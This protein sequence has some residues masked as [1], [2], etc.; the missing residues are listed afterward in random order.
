MEPLAPDIEVPELVIPDIPISEL[1]DYKNIIILNEPIKTYIDINTYIQNDAYAYFVDAQTGAIIKTQ[2]NIISLFDG[3]QNGNKLPK[4]ALFTI[5]KDNDSDLVQILSAYNNKVFKSDGTNLGAYGDKMSDLTAGHWEA[6]TMET[7][8]DNRVII[9][10][11]AG[12]YG[13]INA[14]G[15]FD[16]SGTK[17][18]AT[19][20]YFVDAKYDDVSLY[21]E[22]QATGKYIKSNGVDQPLTVDGVKIDGNI[23]DDLRYTPVWGSYG[24]GGMTVTFNSKAYPDTRWKGGSTDTVTQIGGAGHGGWESIDIVPNGD[25]TISFRDTADMKYFTVSSNGEITKTSSTQSPDANGKFII[26]SVLT[27]PSVTNVKVTDITDTGATVSWTGITDDNFYTGYIVEAIPKNSSNSKIVSTETTKNEIKIEGLVTGAQYDIYVKTV[28][29]TSPAGITEDAITITAKAIA[30]VTNVTLEEKSN[31]IKITFDTVADATSYNIYRAKSAYSEYTKLGTTTTTEF[32]DSNLNAEG[33]YFN[34]YKIVP[35]TAIGEAQLT[36]NFAS[37]ETQMFGENMIIFSEHDPVEKINEVTAH[38]YELQ[39]DIEADAQFNENRF[40][41]YFKPGDYTDINNINLGFYTHI[42]GLGKTPYDVKLSNISIPAYLPDN[43]ATCNF[44]RS[45]ENVSIMDVE[46]G[47]AE[48]SWRADQF[49]WGVAQAAPLRRIYSERPISYDWNYGWA[50]G[51]YVADSY[52]SGMDGD[53]NS[54][55][56]HSGQQFYTRNTTTDGNVFGTTLNN[57]FQG[58]VAP[59]IDD[60][61]SN[62]DFYELK[63]GLGYSNWNTAGADNNQQVFTSITETEKLKEKPFLFIDDDNEYKI[64][65]PSLRENTKGHSWT[66]TD[67]GEGTAMSLDKFYIA[68]EGDTAATINAQLEA[69]KNIFF[70]P[71]IYYAEEVIE[72]KGENT[73]VL[74]TGMASI[75]PTNEE[76]AMS[77]DDVSGVTVAGLIFDAG[78]YSEYLIKVGEKGATLDHSANPTMLIDLFFRIGGTTDV[79]TK[80]DIAI[81]INSSDVITD[82]FWIWRADHGAGVAW[83][84]NVS[85]NGLIVNGDD[86]IAYALFNEHFQE[87][88]TLWTGE[89]GSTFFYQ[90]ETAYDPIS[91]E[92]WMSHNGTVNGYASYKVD[93]NVENHYAVGMGVYNVFIFTGPTYD[94]TEVQIELDNAIEVPNAPNVL[95]ENA[96]IQTFADDQKVLQKINSIVNG[97]GNPVSSGTDSETGEVGTGWSRSFLISY[98]DGTAVVGNPVTSDDQKNKYIG[99]KTITDI[100]E[101]GATTSNTVENLLS[102]MTIEEKV[103]QMLQPEANDIT[104]EQVAEYHIGSL[105]SGGGSGTSGDNT[106]QEWAERATKYHKAAI[107]GF[108]IPLLY[109]VDAVHGHNNVYGATIFPHNIGLGQTGNAQLVEEIGKLTTKEMLATGANWNFTPTL[110]MPRNERWGRTYETY[111]ENVA[112]VTKLGASLIKGVQSDNRAAATAKHFIGEGITENGINQGDVPMDYDSAEFQKIL[113][114]ELALPYIEAIKQGV[115]TVMVT[116]NS[117]GGEKSHGNKALLTDYLKG[118]LGFEGIVITDYNG[119]D[120][121]ENTSSYKD[122]LVR[123]INAGIDMLMIAGDHEGQKK[124]KAAYDLILE[125]INED[126]I[127][128]ERIN[129]AVK[130]ILTVKNNIGILTN[131]NLVYPD[132]TLLDDVGSDAHRAVAR[133]AVSQS[134]V[135]LKN[136]AGVDDTVADDTLLEE[137]KDFDKIAVVGGSAD[138][139]GIQSGGWTISWQGST[140]DI[141]EGTTIY[142]GFNEVAPNAEINYIANGYFSDNDYDVAIVVVGED[143][144]AETNGD[145]TPAGL[146]LKATDISAIEEVTKNHPDLPIVAVVVA[147]RPITIADQSDHFDAIIMAGLP[148]T[149]GAGVADVLLGDEDFSGTLTFTWPWYA[150]DIEDKFTDA[151]KVM[152]EYGR[153]LTKS[154]LTPLSNTKPE[155]PTIVDLSKTTPTKIEAESFSSKHDGI[156]VSGNGQFLEYIQSGRH[157]NYKVS[158][159]EDSVYTV[160]INAATATDDNSVGLDF[161]VDDVLYSSIK[162]PITHTGGWDKFQ[163]LVVGDVNLPKGEYELKITSTTADYNIDYYQFTYKD[164]NFVRPE[165]P[166]IDTGSGAIIVE[167]GVSVTM[168]SSENSQSMA[169]Y[170]GEFAIENK[171]AVKEPIDIKNTD[172]SNITSIILDDDTTYQEVLGNGIS[173]EESTIYNLLK[174][175]DEKRKEFLTN[176]IDPVNGMGNTLIRLTIAT[177]DFTAQ[178]FYSYYDGTGTELNGKPDWNNETGNGFSIQKDIDFGIIQVVNEL[179]DIAVDLGVDDEIMFFASSWS[180]PGWMKLPTDASNSYPDNEMLLKGGSLNDEY[181]DEL[182]KYYVRFLEEYSKHGIYF[183]AMTLQNEPVLEINYP[184]CYMTGGQ[185]AELSKAVKE[186][187]AK[188]TILTQEQQDVKLWAFDHNFN[189]AH[190]FMD[191]LENAGGIDYIDGIAFH[192]Y[193]GVPS[194]MGELYE[195]FDGKLTM[196]LT[197]RAIWGAKGANDI[198]NWY[199]NGARSY[200]GWVTMLDS[201]INTHHWVGTPD[202]TLFVQDANNP[203]KYWAT[204]EVYIIGQFTKYVKEGYVRISS[205]N[206]TTDTV[207]NVAFKNPATG[208]IVMIVANGSGKEQQ[209]K[210]ILDGTQFNALIPA[211]NVATYIWEP[212]DATDFKD[213][214]EDL[215]FADATIKDATLQEDGTVGYITEASIITYNLNVPQAGTYKVELDIAIGGE[216]DKNFETYIKQGDST[217]GVIYSSRFNFWGGEWSD[218]K[219]YQTYI[220]FAEAGLQ[221]INLGFGSDGINL[222]DIHFTKE[223]DTTSLPGKLDANNTM[224]TQGLVKEGDAIKNFG[225]ISANDSAEYKVKVSANG[226]YPIYV[227]A[228]AE[229]DAKSLTVLAYNDKYSRSTAVT[230]VTVP[231]KNTGSNS[232]YGISTSS[233]DLTTDIDSI[234]VKFNTDGVN[235]RNISIGSNMTATTSEELK[236]GALTNKVIALTLENATLTD[237]V[238]TN[239]ISLELPTGVNYTVNR[240]SDTQLEIT[241]TSEA[242]V[243]F[244]TPY[245]LKVN[246]NASAF[247]GIA[248][249]TLEDTVTILAINDDEKLIVSDTINFE[250][251]DVKVT[252]E[253]GTF[254]ENLEDY[255]T[256]TG[257]LTEYVN[258]SSV[259]K[260]SNNTATISLNWEPMYEDM[261]GTI[262]ITSEGYSEGSLELSSEVTFKGTTDLPP[263]AYEI[264]DVKVDLNEAEAFRANGSL[265]NNLVKGNYIDYFVDVK[266][267]GEYRFIYDVYTESSIVDNALKLSGGLGLATDNLGSV[268]FGAYWSQY[269]G[270]GK[271]IH[272][273][274]LKAGKQTIRLEANNAGFE[275]NGFSIEKVLEPVTVGTGAT[276]IT[277]NNVY[278][279]ST[280]KAWGFETKDNQ[281]NIGCSIVDSFQEYRINVTNAGEY[282]LKLNAGTGSGSAP[283]AVITETLS[284]GSSTALGEITIPKNDWNTFVTTDTITVN[285][286][287]GEHI[288]RISTAVDGFNYRSFTLE[289]NDVTVPTVDKTALT[290]LITSATQNLATATIS[291]DGTD[292]LPTDKWVT[293]AEH[294]ALKNAIAQAQTVVDNANA[295]QAQVDTA[296]T[297]LTTANNTFNSVKKDGTNSFPWIE[298]NGIEGGRIKFNPSTGAIIDVEET[299]ASAN[300][301]KTIDGITVISIGDNAFRDCTELSSITLPDSITSIGTAAFFGTGIEAIKVPDSVTSIGDGAFHS[302]IYLVEVVLPASITIGVDVFSNNYSLSVIY[303]GGTEQQ[304]EALNVNV[305]D[306]VLVLF[307]TTDMESWITVAGIEGG[308]IKFDIPNKT[309]IAAEKTITTADIPDT[310][311]GIAVERILNS[312]FEGNTNLTEITL[313]NSITSMPSLGGCENLGQVTLPTSVTIIED[314]V[315]ASCNNVSTINYKGTYSQWSSISKSEINI[316]AGANIVCIDTTGLDTWINVAG[317]EGGKVLFNNTTGMI[318]DVE[319]TVTVANIPETINNVDV[320]SIGYKAFSDCNNLTT[321]TISETAQ[322]LTTIGNYAFYNCSSLSTIELGNFIAVLGEF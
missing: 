257:A 56:T 188:S 6:F 46:T 91:Q 3:A 89:N 79:L 32:T 268:T 155:D 50:S 209:F 214:T 52:I 277:V 238:S 168:S 17:E 43:N 306:S 73:I 140:G 19:E 318:V 85:T 223:A 39:N 206:G 293:Q 124:W 61:A 237:T 190:W 320:K 189:D 212:V 220:T 231:L 57:F 165:L 87:Y 213:I 66:E 200:N 86:V 9:K 187:L 278:N 163:P 217:L 302:C 207:T 33:K 53:G 304:W 204:P 319:P 230:E 253:G 110:G 242:T 201:N 15:N 247:N 175:T 37:L 227:E 77:V 27:A 67:M 176:L 310:I 164:N 68:K 283:K 199:R 103:A 316:P 174:M 222:K 7:T 286:T 244:D 58:V 71:G 245:E 29:G 92:A 271:Y 295:T 31:A 151:S 167:D 102:T 130:R 88:H 148:G 113:D 234:V 74:G 321:L 181:I 226:T 252:L 180:P 172:A 236:E 274:T 205:T 203:E 312:A 202:P 182:A 280:D 229:A 121:I 20:L 249:T 90:N 125:A 96:C 288:I 266:E 160:T 270:D 16:M 260:T 322:N 161:Y 42:G 235:F 216:W 150:E 78:N 250:Q 241:L 303:Y 195:E 255:I 111:S 256:L 98:N 123:G 109:G 173:L 294:N 8:Q 191:A 289:N 135:L 251:S 311:H 291:T 314:I 152:F 285:L 166:D 94:S 69:G 198:I 146:R 11:H 106:A 156:I 196:H 122:Q 157:M 34:Y 263:V 179:Q 267:A 275:I 12:N 309:I 299:V 313:P 36:D 59:N 147:G 119:I 132:A 149:E 233:I 133:N 139:I 224:Y 126:L 44:W 184:S 264:E 144:Y 118:E 141:T 127:T 81:E 301:P 101:I 26:H 49:N 23:G 307:E 131:P 225:F 254:V 159:E 170:K 97:V 154:E 284:D 25:G 193:G 108:G 246:L 137:L 5:I 55:G 215:T 95:I 269:N 221:S 115:Q 279:V 300:I 219:K 258:I 24:E 60:L 72:I 143:P 38:I 211:G 178:D 40:G 142:E 305:S 41:I 162:A 273:L 2:D 282:T 64:F 82:H 45:T 210:V 48:G 169:W 120:Q 116:Y 153:G 197:E 112:D 136:S 297:T 218:F 261:I 287:A 292:I 99:T 47:T 158:V 76:A 35:V 185:Q 138:D 51:G 265:E 134:L 208:E 93:N 272:K 21:I 1:S 28:N 240:I 10:N 171:N 63:S 100:P 290:T 22:H 129:D 259:Q 83:D 194:T 75:I 4:E 54:A 296:K 105:L 13:V 186:E 315:F 18:N 62:N 14:D 262:V 243:D 104:P 128:E 117:I 183:Y 276:T 248:G 145:R 281:L 70:T 239:D 107:D 80:A 114:E 308:K 84:G 232:T 228:A 298:V 192:P 317:I 30:P 65:V 177:S